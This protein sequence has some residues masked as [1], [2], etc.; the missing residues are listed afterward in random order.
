[1]FWDWGKFAINRTQL[2]VQSNIQESILNQF[3]TNIDWCCD[4]WINKQGKR[5]GKEE[6]FRIWGDCCRMKS[7][8]FWKNWHK[9]VFKIW[10]IYLYSVTNAVYKNWEIGL[11]ESENTYYR[12]TIPNSGNCCRMKSELFWQNWHYPAK[13][14]WIGSFLYITTSQGSRGRLKKKE[15]AK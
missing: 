6:Q 1:M 7:E 15:G 9:C 11:R 10:K 14:V 5:N 8:L 12:R 3:D 13:C 2:F 4:I